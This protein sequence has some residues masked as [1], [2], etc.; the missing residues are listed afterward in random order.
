MAIIDRNGNL[1][2]SREDTER[3]QSHCRDFV[4]DWKNTPQFIRLMELEYDAMFAK[5]NPLGKDRIR[6]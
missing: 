3:L 6:D 1:R 2:N 4:K 5:G